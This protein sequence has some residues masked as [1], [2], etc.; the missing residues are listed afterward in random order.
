MV[1]HRSIF[2]LSVLL[3]I[4]AA[5]TYA[6]KDEATLEG[7]WSLEDLDVADTSGKGLD[8]TVIGDPEIVDGAVGSALLFDG[9][10][11]WSASSKRRRY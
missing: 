5:A 9:I 3:M 11:R 6:A 10:D 8:G 2:L 7:E 1:K 4:I